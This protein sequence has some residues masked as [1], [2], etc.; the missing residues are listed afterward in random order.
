MV[1]CIDGTNGLWP[2]LLCCT[3]C[4]PKHSFSTSAGITV[5]QS[6]LAFT[7]CGE[8]PYQN[9]WKNPII[10]S[11]SSEFLFLFPPALPLLS[12]LVAVCTPP[13]PKLSTFSQSS[14]SA[15]F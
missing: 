5:I 10:P 7:C 2:A 9:G 13:G 15:P 3:N 14:S 1:T 4:F 8:W 11:Q 12:L 6:A